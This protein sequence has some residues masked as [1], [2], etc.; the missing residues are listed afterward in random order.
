MANLCKPITAYKF[1]IRY[2][3]KGNTEVFTDGDHAT[4]NSIIF[5]TKNIN[6]YMKFKK[7]IMVKCYHQIYG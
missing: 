7:Y 4:S 3:I 2:I 1:H 6:I 5:G